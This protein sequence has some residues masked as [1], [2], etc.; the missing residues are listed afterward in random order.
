MKENITHSDKFYYSHFYEMVRF[1]PNTYIS[2]VEIS[3]YEILIFQL[4]EFFQT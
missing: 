2:Q 3:R 1:L 4:N